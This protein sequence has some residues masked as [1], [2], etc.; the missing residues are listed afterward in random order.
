MHLKGY[1]HRVAMG[2]PRPDGGQRRRGQAARRTRLLGEIVMGKSE[3]FPEV[4]LA[5]A[6]FLAL[7][8]R[9]AVVLF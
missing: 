3:L 1:Y 9:A 6:F 8:I 7:L 4:V 2:N 5:A